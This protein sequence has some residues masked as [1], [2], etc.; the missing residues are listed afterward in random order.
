MHKSAV[1]FRCSLHNPTILQES[2]E[3]MRERIANGKVEI[4]PS[5]YD[6]A[7]VAMVP[8][9]EYSGGA[10]SQPCFPQCLNWIIENQNSDGSWGLNPGHPSLVKDSLS[11]TLACLPSANGTLPTNKS[12]KDW[13]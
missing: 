9:R 4:T 3:R 2:I 11:C 12:I 1:A 8:E 6:T 10:I 5:A 13:N 7:W